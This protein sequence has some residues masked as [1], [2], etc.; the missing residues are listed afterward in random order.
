MNKIIALFFLAFALVAVQDGHA[1]PPENKKGGKPN[2]EQ[3]D[4]KE[5]REDLRD[6]QDGINLVSSLISADDARNL[7]KASG[8]TGYKP[9]P[10]G[11]QKN[12]ARGKPLPPGIEKTRMPGGMLDKLPKQK[13][14]EWRNAG[15]DLLLVQEGT[16]IVAD[17]LRDVF[18]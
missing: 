8:A 15:A 6:L 4:K 16:E 14:Y 13:G 3:H 12:L 5:D 10:P 9:L 11:I 1:K 18:K 2:K 17:V 7:A